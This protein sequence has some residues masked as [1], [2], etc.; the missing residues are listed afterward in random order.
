MAKKRS[1]L[2]LIGLVSLCALVFASGI[3]SLGVVRAGGD[4]A[5]FSYETDVAAKWGE[6]S[7]S[8]NNATVANKD[9]WWND[10]IAGGHICHSWIEF[11]ATEIGSTDCYW[12]SVCNIRKYE[13][14]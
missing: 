3:A 2:F 14:A 13:E 9:K 6:W 10:W 11:M 12:D 5:T 4:S 1:K 7:Y 8:G